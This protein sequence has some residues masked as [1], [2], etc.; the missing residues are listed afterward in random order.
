MEIDK[1]MI[2]IRKAVSIKAAG[3]FRRDIPREDKIKTGKTRIEIMNAVEDTLKAVNSAA[4]G[5]TKTVD[6]PRPVKVVGSS[7]E[8]PAVLK[9]DI[10]KVVR[11]VNIKTKTKIKTEIK[12]MNAAAALPKAVLMGIGK[13]K[14]AVLIMVKSAGN[15][16]EDPAVHNSAVIL[17]AIKI[18]KIEI[19]GIAAA[20]ILK[21]IRGVLKT[22]NFNL[23]KA[24]GNSGEDSAVLKASILKPMKIG[25][26]TR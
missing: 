4:T 2:P 25:M 11:T 22:A 23:V 16:V 14:T 19:K 20:D 5:K 7:M 24:V 8:H 17:Q 15:S 18:G 6:G 21:A 13:M 1:N 12:A 3:A 10:L 26:K 9:A